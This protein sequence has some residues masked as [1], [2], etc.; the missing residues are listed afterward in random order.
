MSDIQI[1]N[2]SFSAW[3]VIPVAF[4]IW[5]TL[6]LF[7]KK[8]FFSLVKKITSKTANQIDD[9]F[10]QSADFPI[11]LLVFA[12]G[13]ALVERMMPLAME[14]ELTT[15]FIVAFKVVAIVAIILFC[16]RFLGALIHSYSGKVEILKT[17]GGVARG[18]RGGWTPTL[19]V[20][21]WRSGA[22]SSNADDEHHQ[23]WCARRQRAGDS[24]VHGGA[25]GLR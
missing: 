1:L 15:Y 20:P 19:A 10:V 24:R 14:N 2:F 9:L 16:D 8:R 13:G 21:R 6:L 23:W 5:V 12:S 17:S 22:R 3:I 11:T 4:F 25:R 18:R 7:V